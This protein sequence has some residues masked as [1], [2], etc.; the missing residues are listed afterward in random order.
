MNMIEYHGIDHFNPLFFSQL[1]RRLAGASR[2]KTG[3]SLGSLPLS[4]AGIK[5]GTSA[6][7]PLHPTPALSIENLRNTTWRRVGGIEVVRL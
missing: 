1:E 6:P 2:A 7:S 5:R 3:G 4:H